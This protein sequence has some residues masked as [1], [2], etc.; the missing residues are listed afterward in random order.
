M[1]ITENDY[2]GPVPSTPTNEPDYLLLISWVFVIFCSSCMFIKSTKGQQWI[3]KVRIL[4]Q[5]HQ[6]IDWERTGDTRIGQSYMYL[7]IPKARE[8]VKFNCCQSTGSS[9][10]AVWNQRQWWNLYLS[11]DIDKAMC[12]FMQL[13]VD[14]GFY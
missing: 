12:P 14:Q 9:T 7:I 10:V 1:N 8:G 6:H 3:N 11:I 5:E 4:W 2:T 13:P